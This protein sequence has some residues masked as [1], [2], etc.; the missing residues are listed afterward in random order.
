ML[1]LFIIKRLI[2]T[3]ICG[4]IL[5]ISVLSTTNYFIHQIACILYYLLVC[6]NESISYGSDPT[7]RMLFMQI[8]MTTVLNIFTLYI[9]KCSSLCCLGPSLRVM[10][11]IYSL[12]QCRSA[13]TSMYIYLISSM[14]LFYVNFCLSDFSIPGGFFMDIYSFR[15]MYWIQYQYL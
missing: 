10:V 11:F 3:F 5:K 2:A 15:F 12:N 7:V 1:I 4:Y 6:Y 8:V 9:I 14:I 13:L